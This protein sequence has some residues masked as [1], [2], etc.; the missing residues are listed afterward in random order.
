MTQLRALDGWLSEE[1]YRCSESWHS[2]FITN[3]LPY[4]YTHNFDATVDLQR[5]T[6]LVAES[7]NMIELHQPGL[8]WY[9]ET[10]RL[11]GSLQRHHVAY[12][13]IELPTIV[14]CQGSTMEKPLHRPP[15]DTLLLRQ[16]ARSNASHAPRLK[17]VSPSPSSSPNMPFRKRKNP[18]D[19]H[20]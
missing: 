4:V 17:T 3:A 1:S 11:E 18:P 20:D 14:P 8:Q 12:E 19:S 6:T 16:Q 9:M 2:T 5:A 7:L 13:D 15:A 10:Y